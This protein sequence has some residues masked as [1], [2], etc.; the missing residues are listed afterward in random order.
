LID[1]TVSKALATLYYVHDPMCSWCWGFRPVWQQVQS[2]LAGKLTIRY[3]LGGLAADSDMPMS[4]DMQANIKDTWAH[5]QKEIPGTEFNFAFWTQN[6]P[7]RS[8]YPACRALIAAG[9]Q[10]QAQAADD[11]LLAIQ[12][13]YYLQAKN[14]SDSDVLIQ[15]AIDSGLD[16]AQFKTDLFSVQCELLLQQDLQMVDKLGVRGFPSL[17]LTCNGSNALISIDYTNSETIVSSI[18]ATLQATR[19]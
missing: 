13:A 16:A 11:M 4:A 8:T 19:R 17:V 3:L 18:L 2:A 7:R 6:Q 10:G 15:L 9:L 14:P 12:Q 5:I 1:L